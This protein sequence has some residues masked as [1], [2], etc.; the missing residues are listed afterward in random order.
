MKKVLIITG[1][2]AGMVLILSFCSGAEQPA[3]ENKVEVK[4]SIDP[5]AEGEYLITIMG[6]HDCHSPKQMTEKG[7]EVIPELAWSGYPANRALPVMSMDAIKKGWGIYNHD[8]TAFVGPWGTSFAANLTSDPTG[9]GTWTEDQ[10][11][12]ALVEGWYKGVPNSRKLLPPMPY[13]NL[14]DLRDE[15]VHALYMYLKSTTAV[16]NVPPQP[17]PPSL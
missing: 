9:I 10:F 11:R 2:L 7:P 4:A 3:E 17:I 15:D 13:Q 16:R 1:I 12:L 8:L 14:A 5:V 6:C